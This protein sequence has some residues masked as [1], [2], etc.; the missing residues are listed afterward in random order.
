MV[1]MMK[2]FNIFG[3]HWKFQPFFWGGGG[4]QKTNIDVEIAEKGDLDSLLI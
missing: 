2:N 1:W 4:S 3:V